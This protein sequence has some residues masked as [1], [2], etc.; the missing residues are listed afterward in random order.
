MNYKKAGLLRDALLVIGW[1][2][3]L[4]TSLWRPFA[5]IGGIVTVSALIP[6]I[7]FFRCPYCRKQLG[8]FRGGYCPFCGKHIDDE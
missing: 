6:H 2:L 3:I 8:R 7:L 4:L 5:M 1:I